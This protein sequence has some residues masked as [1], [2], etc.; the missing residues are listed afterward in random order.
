VGRFKGCGGTVRTP[1]VGKIRQGEEAYQ[2]MGFVR[3]LVAR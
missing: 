2:S 1:P 3:G